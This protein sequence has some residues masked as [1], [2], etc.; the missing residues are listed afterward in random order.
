M[1][2]G[3]RDFSL[4]LL[5]AAGASALPGPSRAQTGYPTRPVTIIVPY[6]AGG[7]MDITGRMIFDK[8]SEWQPKRF[9]LEAK[10]GAGGA[11]GAEAVARATPDGHTILFTAASGLVTLAVTSG[12]KLNFDPFTD[13]APIMTLSRRPFVMMADPA[14]GFT[15][16]QEFVA[17]ARENPGKYTYS[18]TGVGGSDYFTV[19]QFKQVAGIDLLHI[20]YTGGAAAVTAV[21]NGEVSINFGGLTQY[22]QFGPSG[23]VTGLGVS[24]AERLEQF[25]DLPVLTEVAP[26]FEA[27]VTLDFF[28]PRGIPTEIVDTLRDL[29]GRA[30]QE[31]GV[32]ERV[33]EQGALVDATP[34]D[35][36]ARMAADRTAYQSIVDALGLTFE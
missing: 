3:R 30:I 28:G 2:L 17:A 15:T 32:M 36:S 31:P 24:S 23:Q 12:A 13:L 29:I 33:L 22:Q 8:I 27:W 20:P 26:G 34:A 14:L 18:S 6:N 9:L 25:P 7:P 16:A 21:V 19:E 4:L 1:N 10:P 11:I 5:S 35:I